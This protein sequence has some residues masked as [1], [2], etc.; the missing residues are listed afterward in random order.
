MLSLCPTF[1]V[2]KKL[3]FVISTVTFRG[4]DVQFISLQSY[5]VTVSVSMSRYDGVD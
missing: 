4:T 2:F 5:I 1:Y 3:F